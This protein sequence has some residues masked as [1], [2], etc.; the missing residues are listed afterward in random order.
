MANFEE[1]IALVLR[2]EDPHLTGVVTEDAGGRTRFGIAERFHPELGDEFYEGSAESALEV[3]REIYRSDY[4]RAIHGD[5]IRD[6]SI[7]TKLLDMAVNMGIRQAIVL[8]QRALNALGLQLREDGVIGSRTLA[9]INYADASLLSAYLR[10]CCAA[11]YQ[12]LAAVRP[13]AQQY[14][15]GWL[16][17][18]RA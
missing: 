16:L 4:W 9:A 6:Q 17:R 5:E 14:L 3:A 11:F 13:E 18:A 12:H 2:N 7:A 10:E 15:H 8:C 1:A